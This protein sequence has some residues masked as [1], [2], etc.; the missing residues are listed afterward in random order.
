MELGDEIKQIRDDA[1]RKESLRL[2]IRASEPEESSEKL[3]ERAEE[4]YRYLA[5]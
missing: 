4:F 5:N 3:T 2:A 1:R